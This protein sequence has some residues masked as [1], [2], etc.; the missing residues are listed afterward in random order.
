MGTQQAFVILKVN[1]STFF[2]PWRHKSPCV[3]KAGHNLVSSFLSLL[4]AEITDMHHYA[5]IKKKFCL[6]I[7]L[8][9]YL[10][11]LVL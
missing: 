5:Q 10:M 3:V 9:T 2:P 11:Y 1:F 4:N 8:L 6:L 7:Y